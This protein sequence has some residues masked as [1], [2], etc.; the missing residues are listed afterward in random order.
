MSSKIKNVLL[1]V[2]LSLV[3]LAL[4]ST[5]F[6]SPQKEYTLSE[7]RA[8]AQMPDVSVKTLL[9]GSFMKDFESFTLD[10]FPARDSFRTLK[11][12]TS[13]RVLSYLTAN[14]LYT[15][16]GYIVKEEYPLNNEVVSGN[17]ETLAKLWE[18]A[19]KD[20][21]TRVFFS[22]IPDKNY[23]FAPLSNRLLYDTDEFLSTVRE[24]LPF[25]EYIDVTDTLSTD[26]YYMTD[27]HWSQDKIVGTAEKLSATLG[28][29]IQSEY[30]AKT[31]SDTFWGVYTKQLLLPVKSDKL[32][33]LSNPTLDAL[34][35]KVL[36][37]RGM[38][39]ESSVYNFEKLSAEDMYD[40]FLSG[41]VPMV[42]IENPSVTDGS[43]LVIFRDSFGSSMAPLLAQGYSK[44]TV[45]DLRYVNTQFLPML[46]NFEN[47]DVLFM[48]SS[49]VLNSPKVF[50]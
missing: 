1:V 20:K 15:W 6:L 38:W 11:M 10:Q 41:A 31:A 46:V 50:G 34:K 8:L 23:Y 21:N 7:R 19:M 18:T 49:I 39:E 26:S 27:T 35:V 45:V 5:L 43:H 17:L 25:A 16:N 30:E 32:V 48:Y 42:E 2:I 9:N 28:T 40:F 24:K 12:F 47:A 37:D 4:A 29:S 14:D 13:L 3:V 22:F 44:T 33:Y 36:N